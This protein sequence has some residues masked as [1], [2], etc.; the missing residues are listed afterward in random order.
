L[1]NWST[2]GGTL[3]RTTADKH[4]GAA[5]ALITGRTANWNGIVFDVGNLTEGHAYVVSVWVKLAAGSAASEL[6]LTAKRQDDADPSTYNEFTRVAAASASAGGWTQLRGVYTQ[7][8][9]PF[10]HFIIESA[11]VSVSFYVDDFSISGEVSDDDDTCPLPSTFQWTSTGPLAQPKS[12]WVSLK[13]FTTADYNGKHIVYMT[14]HDTGSSWG[15]AMMIFNDWSQMGTAQQ[16]ALPRSAVAPTLFYFAPKNIWV[17]TYQWGG[18]AFSYATSNDPT[19]PNGWAWGQT[20]FNGSISGSSTGPIDQT[21]ICDNTT[22]HLFFTG[23][24]GK[25]YRSSMPIGNFP[26][27]FGAATTIMSDSQNNLFEAVQV[28]AVKG[29]NQYL[30]IVE[31]IGGGGRYFRSFTATNLGGSWTPLAASESRPF[32]GKANVTFQNGSAWTNDISHGD[33]IR[34]SP[35]QTMTIDPCHLQMLYQGRNPN[36]GGD[37]GKL[38]YRPGLLTFRK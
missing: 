24:N 8:G 21:V 5:S 35:D 9:T 14:T 2:T 7:S 12:G 34:V 17:L 22:C 26:G 38:P 37:Y 25:I 18:P 20:L 16:I 27:T 15:S 19:N 4:S 11:D 10:Q 13:D 23:D 31:A 28:Y 6:Y 36:S 29:S 33:L 30:M 32:A 3:T 1:T